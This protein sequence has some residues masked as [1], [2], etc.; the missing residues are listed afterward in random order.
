MLLQPLGEAAIGF[1]DLAAARRYLD[2]AV[3][4]ARAIPNKR[5]L[6][7]ALNMLAH[8]NRLE[9]RLEEA[10]PLY[11][12]AVA[13]VR[14]LGD[15][16]SIAIG[17]LNLAMVAIAGGADVR[18][19]PILVE[20]LAIADEIGSRLVGQSVLEVCAALAATRSDWTRAARYYGAAEA[21]AAE[22]GLRRDSADEAF[23]APRIAMAR[24]ALGATDY[25]AAESAGRAVTHAVVTGDVRGWLAGRS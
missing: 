10:E 17:L 3:E 12:Q 24:E 21:Q 1:G 16:E 11:G 25:A 20:A 6:A 19:T 23:L 13:L 4:R 5:E 2:E 14:E 8:V 22:T 18:A 15:R 7:A 9:G